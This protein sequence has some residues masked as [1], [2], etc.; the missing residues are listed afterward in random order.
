MLRKNARIFIVM[1]KIF[2]L[3][4]NEVE[5]KARVAPL[6]AAGYEVAYHWSTEEHAKFGEA[7]PE[8]VV[9][10]LDRLPSHGRAV[11]EWFWEAKKRQHIPLLF[12]GG[13]PEK[14]KATK[15]KFPKAIFCT[16]EEVP[17]ILANLFRGK[18]KAA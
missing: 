7:L 13:Q 14:V 10:S 12:A 1:A 16:A 11:A 2:Y 18:P 5:A 17:E 15:A 8:A 9:I 4:W 3:H 6:A